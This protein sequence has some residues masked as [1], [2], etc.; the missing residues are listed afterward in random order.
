MPPRDEE[1][2]QA[3]VANYEA[4]QRELAEEANW[5]GRKQRKMAKWRGEVEMD[6]R[7][8]YSGTCPGEDSGEC[9]HNI[10]NNLCLSVLNMLFR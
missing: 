5:G 10:D 1:Q 6:S 2:R 3:I 4:R 9:N 8:C 7:K